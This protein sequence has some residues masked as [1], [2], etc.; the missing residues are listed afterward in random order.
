LDSER[1]E[2]QDF[3]VDCEMEVD[4]G[5]AAQSDD[6]SETVN[7]AAVAADVVAIIEGEPR[8]LIEKVVAE[9]A[10]TV[11]AN[12]EL[13]QGAVI[14]LHKPQA[15]V[16]VPFGDVSIRTRRRR[17]M[18]V[19][20][21]VGA[22]VGQPQEAVTGGI[23]ELSDIPG[24]WGVRASPSYRTTPVGGPA[25]DDYVNAVAVART[26]LSPHRLL[27]QLQQVEQRW[28]RS[29]SLRW[30]PRTLDLDLVQYGGP[31]SGGE[32]LLND[33][34]LC[35]PHPRAHQRAFVLVPWLAVDGSAELTVDGA[36]AEVSALVAGLD[37]EGVTAIDPA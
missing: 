33:P 14:T 9:I 36:L 22:N 17:D 8:N 30:G 24:V 16:G 11:L 4:T 31:S 26:S 15:P 12:Y 19:V 37:T 28:G 20:I 32:R 34:V 25:Q 18:P 21:A 35:L 27:E 29:R 6:V 13:V 1:L 5:P 2:G 10:D 3:I 7:Y 23:R